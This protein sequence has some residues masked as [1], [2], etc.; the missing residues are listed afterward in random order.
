MVPVWATVDRFIS[1]LLHQR[2]NVKPSV[3]SPSSP[4]DPSVLRSSKPYRGCSGGSD[5]MRASSRHQPFAWR[6][7]TD[8]LRLRHYLAVC[9]ATRR[10]SQCAPSSRFPSPQNITAAPAQ[11]A[12]DGCEI[13]DILELF[14]STTNRQCCQ[15]PRWLSSPCSTKT[16]VMNLLR[17]PV[18]PQGPAVVHA[19][20]LATSK[21]ASHQWRRV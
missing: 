16:Y 17:R 3:C 13:V 11:K 18:G 4:I 6:T 14:S 19:R 15:P 2:C 10:S 9:R 21:P 20:R 1:L 8:D 7:W 5:H 12:G